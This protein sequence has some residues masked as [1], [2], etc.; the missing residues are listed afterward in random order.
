ME[1][2]KSKKVRVYCGE[3]IV[4]NGLQTQ[5]HPTQEVKEANR[6]ICSPIDEKVYSNSPDFVLAIKSIG[7]K[8]KVETEFFLNGE[9]CGSDIEPIFE[10]FN[11]AYS[12]IEELCK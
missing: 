9:S 11:R 12:M 3:T 7:D 6:I 1:S 4:R 8:Y 10:D 5:R 2:N